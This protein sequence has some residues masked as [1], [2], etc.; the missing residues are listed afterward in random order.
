VKTNHV[1]TDNRAEVGTKDTMWAKREEAVSDQPLKGPDQRGF[2]V[3][4]AGQKKR[5][6]D[7]LTISCRN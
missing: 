7:V 3:S 6:W 1:F 5:E 2:L 4:Q